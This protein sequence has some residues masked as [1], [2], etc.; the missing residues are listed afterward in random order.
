M[1]SIHSI[2]GM[3]VGNHKCTLYTPEEE[4]R[5]EMNISPFH[6]KDFSMSSGVSLE[7]LG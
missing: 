1:L 3:P 6:C 2:G 5:Y 4:A 7:S